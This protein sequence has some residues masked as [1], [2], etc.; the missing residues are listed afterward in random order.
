MPRLSING[1]QYYYEDVGTGPETVVF[2]H[3]F[4]M[5]HRMWEH[6]VEALRDRYRCIAFDWRGQGWSEVTKSGYSVLELCEDLVEL[7][8]RLDTGPVHYVGLSMGGF[9]G[10]RLLL[11]DPDWLQSATLIDTQADAETGSSRLRYEAMLLIARTIG[12]E[13]VIDRTLQMMFGPAFLN[14]PNNEQAIERWRG[15]ATSNSRVGVYR[16]GQ[17]I[18]QRPNVLPLLGAIRTP[19]LLMTG[20]DDTPTPVDAARRAQQAIP[21]AELTV[22][23]AAGH[24]SPIE[25]PEAVT[26]RLE[27]FIAAHTAV[28]AS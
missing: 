7:V 22:I 5:T 28:P 12:Y 3:G 8:E 25:R 23:P 4:L 21:K 13:P 11:R 20:S 6:Q 19:T 2:G 26:E 15:I 18:F 24:S 27:S 1:C 10:F 9:V 16:A 17:A 14:N